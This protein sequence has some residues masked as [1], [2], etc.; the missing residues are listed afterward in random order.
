MSLRIANIYFLLS[1]LIIVLILSQL[2]SFGYAMEGLDSH[3]SYLPA[4]FFPS[5]DSN[6]NSRYKNG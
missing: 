5:S 2:F 3:I 6:F 1:I 4:E